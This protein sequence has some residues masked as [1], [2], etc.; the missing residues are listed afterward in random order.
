MKCKKCKVEIAPYL[1]KCPLCNTKIEKQSDNHSYNNVV[2]N[3]STRINVIYFSRLIMKVLLLSNIICILLNIIINKKVDWSLYVIF[4]TLFIFSFYLYIVLNN[5]KTAF[6]LNVFFLELLL[7]MLA[8]LT[9]TLSW[10]T[11]L[12]GP[13]I[14]E[15]VLFILL[16]IY[17]SKYRNIIRNFSCILVYISL[18]LNLINGLIMVYNTN[19]FSLTW[20]IYSSAPLL[21]ISVILMLLS[22]NKKISEEIE[23]RFF[24]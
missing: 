4:S 23:K 5:K 1:D 14:L 7:F 11:C 19:R 8:F 18:V 9:N 20:S 13:F 24:I 21:I 17:L 22:F 3:F 2:E 16:N 15:I 12:V 10:F 6:L